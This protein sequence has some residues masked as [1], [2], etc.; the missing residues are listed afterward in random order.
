MFQKLLDSIGFSSTIFENS[1]ASGGFAPEP[2]TNAYDNIYLNYWQNFSEKFDNIILKIWKNGKNSI[3]T[4][5][6]L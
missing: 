1:L 3:R 6:K 5:Q 2:P 4:I